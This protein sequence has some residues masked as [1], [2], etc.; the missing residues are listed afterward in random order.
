[1]KK[2]LSNEIYPITDKIYKWLLVGS[3]IMI[4]IRFFSILFFGYSIFY[5]NFIYYILLSYG[6]LALFEIYQISKNIEIIN[7]IEKNKVRFLH[8]QLNRYFRPAVFISTLM[9]L[10]GT[11]VY[12]TSNFA[13]FTFG[14][15]AVYMLLLD[16]ILFK[17]RDISTILKYTVYLILF[18]YIISTTYIFDSYFLSQFTITIVDDA[19]GFSSSLVTGL[20]LTYLL[21]NV[22]SYILS[23]KYNLSNTF[24]NKYLFLQLSAI[25]VWVWLIKI[26][27]PINSVSYYCFLI[28][29]FILCM[30]TITYLQT[31][32][33]IE[34]DKIYSKL[35]FIL[36]IWLNLHIIFT[37][38]LTFEGII[39]ALIYGFLYMLV[40][41]MAYVFQ[42]KFAVKCLEG[43][44]ELFNKWL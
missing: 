33:M 7:L 2:N 42:A 43:I 30:G 8:H 25:A 17:K 3:C 34:N 28:F 15:I 16:L 12:I 36:W 24:I 38:F 5:Y 39:N 1:M 4:T 21:I 19:I 27:N 10:L 22:N 35:I 14:A 40:M 6:S 37:M 41:I 20:I 31:K 23:K 11:N 44:N 18:T 29:I 32:F 9:L 26:A 13:F